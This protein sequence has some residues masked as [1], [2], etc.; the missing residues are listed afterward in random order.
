MQDNY[1]KLRKIIVIII[2]CTWDDI[3]MYL[4]FT[5]IQNFRYCNILT[6]QFMNVCIETAPFL[7]SC[8]PGYLSFLTLRLQC[9]KCTLMFRA[10]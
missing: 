2:S 9:C 5:H 6:T 1:K 7:D 4:F 8:T 10:L 3:I